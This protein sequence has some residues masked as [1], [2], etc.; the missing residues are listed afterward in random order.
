M[1]DPVTTKEL[2]GLLHMAMEKHNL[3][4]KKTYVE[5]TWWDNVFRPLDITDCN[6]EKSEFIM[7][8]GDTPCNTFYENSDG[9]VI[10]AGF[11]IFE[12]AAYVEQV[13]HRPM[14][15]SQVMD[16]EFMLQFDTVKFLFSNSP[17]NCRVDI[18]PYKTRV[19]RNRADE[20]V[21]AFYAENRDAGE[22]APISRM[23]PDHIRLID[24]SPPESKWKGVSDSPA[25]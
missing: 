14:T 12:N 16:S 25:A 5:F 11:W 9:F 22:W 3:D 2:N 13:V 17:V 20:T 18:N 15:V 24:D 21:L 19:Y 4:P 23:K 7:V 1:F 6:W 8:F 10:P